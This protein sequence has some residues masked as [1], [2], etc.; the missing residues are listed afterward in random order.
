MIRCHLGTS[1]A[2]QRPWWPVF[3]EHFLSGPHIPGRCDSLCVDNQRREQFV[4]SHA[5]LQGQAEM[6]S[7]HPLQLHWTEPQ[8]SEQV[9][10]RSPSHC[11]AAHV[12]WPWGE[13]KGITDKAQLGS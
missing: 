7:L 6:Q 4:R 3:A 12:Y 5:A 9:P 1:A 13:F 10:Q 2:L 8:D 11:P